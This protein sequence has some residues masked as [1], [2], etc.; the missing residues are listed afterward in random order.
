MLKRSV[1]EG[2][3]SDN[4]MVC[5]LKEAKCGRLSMLVSNLF[6][7]A[8]Y[9]DRVLQSAHPDDRVEVDKYDNYIFCLAL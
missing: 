3:K 6:E 2:C 8:K 4:W 1:F 7:V 9:S 5:I